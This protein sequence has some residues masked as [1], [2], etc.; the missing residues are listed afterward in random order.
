MSHTSTR[1]KSQI[2]YFSHGGGPLPILGDP[3]HEAMVTFMKDLPTQLRRPEAIVVFSAHWEENT[4]TI[5]SG[6]TPG[7][8]YDYYGFPEEAYQITYPCRGNKPLA[9]KIADLLSQSSI[10]CRLDPQRPYDHGSY[11]P[12]MMMYPEAD[13]PVIQIS[14]HHGLNP[15]TH[16][17]IGKALR[18]LLEDNLLFI[19]SGFSITTWVGLTSGADALKTLLTMTFKTASL[20]FAALIR[21]M[22]ALGTGW[23]TGSSCPVQI[24]ATQGLSISCPCM[25][26][27]ASAVPRGI[28]YSMIIFSGNGPW[29]SYGN[30]HAMLYSSSLSA[31]PQT[32]PNQLHFP[33][34]SNPHFAARP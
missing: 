4:V 31:S 1:N 17:Q 12:L 10:D 16:L 8:L 15:V 32:I 5:Q 3:T 22:K 2:I 9:E 24:T 23:Q 21:R 28:K 14:L 19:G 33:T 11:I 34:G 29:H 20:I 27:Q 18:P 25:Y 30:R 6:E 13:I 7:M 26:A